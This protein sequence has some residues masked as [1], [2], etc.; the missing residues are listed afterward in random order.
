MCR[1]RIYDS[2]MQAVEYLQESW[3]SRPSLNQIL[4]P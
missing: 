1:V 4:V 2:G 3:E